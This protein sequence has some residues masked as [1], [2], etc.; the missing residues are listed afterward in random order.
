[1]MK[2]MKSKGDEMFLLGRFNQDMVLPA[3]KQKNESMIGLNV[4]NSKE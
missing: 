3:K 2:S 4:F 1:M